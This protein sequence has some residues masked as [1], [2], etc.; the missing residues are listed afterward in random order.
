[1]TDSSSQQYISVAGTTVHIV[2]KHISDSFKQFRKTRRQ[3]CL[4]FTNVNSALEVF[5]NVMHYIIPCFTYCIWYFPQSE[6]VCAEDIVSLHTL[7]HFAPF[8]AGCRSDRRT[9]SCNSR[10]VTKWKPRQQLW[11]RQTVENEA[12]FVLLYISAVMF[13]L[14]EWWNNRKDIEHY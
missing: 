3:S 7:H 2:S 4:V 12:I 8:L 14:A 11:Q 10:G 13:T 5:L 6:L 1:V 9:W